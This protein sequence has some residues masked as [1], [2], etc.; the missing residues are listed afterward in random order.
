MAH[1]MVK[2]L[3]RRED[4]TLSSLFFYGPEL[5]L[6]YP[7]EADIEHD[8]MFLFEREDQA[9][10]YRWRLFNGHPLWPSIELWRVQ[11]FSSILPVEYVLRTP[12]VEK[13]QEEFWTRFTSTRLL[14][15]MARRHPGLRFQKAPA[16]AFICYKLRLLECIAAGK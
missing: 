16:G 4:G 9:Q 3:R 8:H 5:T 10:T 14:Q 1:E 7:E 6:S 2:L 15:T 13:F 12:D 11:V